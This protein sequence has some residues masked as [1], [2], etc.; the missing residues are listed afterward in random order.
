MQLFLVVA[1]GLVLAIGIAYIHFRLANP[2][3]ALQKRFRQEGRTTCLSDIL[4]SNGNGRGT[5]LIFRSVGLLFWVP[6]V[7]HEC[8]ALPE[9]A[10]LLDGESEF[11]FAQTSSNTNTDLIVLEINEIAECVDNF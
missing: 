9:N 1:G 2:R 5:V 8:S 11:N 6:E 7:L 3:L 4:G 10:L